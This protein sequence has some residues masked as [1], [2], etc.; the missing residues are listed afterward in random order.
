MENLFKKS[1]LFCQD[2]IEIVDGM[3]AKQLSR[4]LNKRQ[5]YFQGTWQWHFVRRSKG[6][7]NSLHL[8]MPSKYLLSNLFA[9][10]SLSKAESA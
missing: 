5:G 10:S 8:I 4:A 6:P 1:Y 2:F 3:N 7:Y 9:F